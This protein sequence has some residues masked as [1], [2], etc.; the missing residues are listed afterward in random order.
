[1]LT[2]QNIS[3]EQGNK[4]ILRGID[5]HLLKG[6][7]VGLVGPNGSGKSSLLKM[8]SFLERPTSGQLVFQDKIISMG[9]APLEVRRKIALVFQEPLLLNTT[10][11]E[12]IAAGLKIRRVSK[13][14]IKKRVEDWTSRFGIAHLLIEAG[15]FTIWWRGPT[16]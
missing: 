7:R 9:R 6:E 5:F 15:T 2:A 10:V 11:F 12:N 14:E 13:P 8:L 16:R 3:W 1:M 4:H